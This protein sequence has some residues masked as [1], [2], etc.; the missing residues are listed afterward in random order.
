VLVVGEDDERR[1]ALCKTI[2]KNAFPELDYKS[3]DPSPFVFYDG[4][5]LR[6]LSVREVDDNILSK[7]CGF[8][9]LMEDI[10]S[11][12][13]LRVL[14]EDFVGYN[15]LR[16]IWKATKCE[17]AVSKFET[18]KTIFNNCTKDCEVMWID[19]KSESPMAS[20]KIFWSTYEYTAPTLVSVKDGNFRCELPEKISH[21]GEKDEDEEEEKETKEQQLP[22]GYCIIL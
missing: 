7:R 10:D 1:N 12:D 6:L 13:A 17:Q 4:P 2:I 21:I 5:E 11:K 16:K 8:V 20:K 3:S 14:T 18:F 9:V 19:A 15:S 22:D